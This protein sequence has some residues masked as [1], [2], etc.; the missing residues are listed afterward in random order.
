MPVSS[1][2]IGNAMDAGDSIDKVR[3][4]NGHDGVLCIS[5]VEVNGWTACKFCMNAD[6]NYRIP[7]TMCVF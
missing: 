1:E 7:Y 2:L 3:H 4:M 5:I 6:C